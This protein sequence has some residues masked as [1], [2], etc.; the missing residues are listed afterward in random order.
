MGIA[1]YCESF[2]TLGETPILD[3]FKIWYL[4]L[5][6]QDD[7]ADITWLQIFLTLGTQDFE[8]VADIS[9]FV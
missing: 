2:V 6:S 3:L 1:N 4:D 8:Y 7:I 5:S 9:E